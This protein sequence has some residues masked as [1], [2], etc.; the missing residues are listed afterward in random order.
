MHGRTPATLAALYRAK[1]LVGEAVARVTGTAHTLGGAHALFK[2]LP[3]EQLVRDGA[4]TPI[5]LPSSDACPPSLG[6]IGLGLDAHDALRALKRQ[7]EDTAVPGIRQ[8]AALSAALW[9]NN[10]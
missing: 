3:L 2:T 10:V 5:L 7:R 8:E 4:S 6:I 9:H 1:Y